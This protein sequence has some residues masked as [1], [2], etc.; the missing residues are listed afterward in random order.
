[1]VLEKLSHEQGSLGAYEIVLG[2][3]NITAAVNSVTFV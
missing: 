1:M 3:M 2:Q